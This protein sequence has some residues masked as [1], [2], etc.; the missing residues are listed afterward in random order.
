MHGGEIYIRS[1]VESWQVGKECGIFTATDE[2]IEALKPLLAEF[3]DDVGFDLAEV[4]AVP[5]TRL[6]PISHR[7]YGKLYTYL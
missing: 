4:M 3:C 5:F 2:E 7:P 1:E 6:V